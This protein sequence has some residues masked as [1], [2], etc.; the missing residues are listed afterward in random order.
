MTI[1]S[2]S[3]AQVANMS[4]E[5]VAA[6]LGTK[7][8][9]MVG[10]DISEEIRQRAFSMLERIKKI[11]DRDVAARNEMTNEAKSFGLE[12]RRSISHQSELLNQPMQDIMEKNDNLGSIGMDLLA[13][14]RKVEQVN[15]NKFD[16]AESTF[17]RLLGKLPGIGTRL[18][19]WWAQYQSVSVVIN[20]ILEN[21]EKGKGVL[22]QDNQ[23]L[24]AD[25]DKLTGHTWQLLDQLQI[26][27]LLDK[28]L[29]VW[30]ETLDIVQKKYIQED[31]L[32]YLR[33][34]VQDMQLSLGAANQSILVSDIIRRAN[35]ELV[36]STERTLN[37][38][39]KA[40]QTAAALQVALAHQKRQIEAVKATQ[41]MTVDLLKGTAER[42][43]TQ[44]VQVVRDANDVSS[45]I[46]GLKK[47][48]SD[49]IEA[50]DLLDGYKQT[51][52][53]AIQ[54]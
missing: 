9:S 27:M 43:K 51:A 22:I 54:L 45:T 33:Q 28:E 13:L 29:T 24:R 17:R 1:Q 52:L 41:Q 48:F 21:L 3:I 30:A 39:A 31:V 6:E 38:S 37:V 23:T 53:P 34:E 26:A 10:K 32:Y 46:D 50:M 49:T 40:L 7:T 2:A 5:E 4:P 25:R 16:F 15:P 19:A 35:E 18:E 8:P 14:I 42:A 11:G 36:R 12:V 20:D 47:A 44:G